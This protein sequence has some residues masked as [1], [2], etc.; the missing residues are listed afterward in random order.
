VNDSG[1]EHPVRGIQDWAE[2]RHQEDQPAPY[3]SRGEGLGIP[4]K[5]SHWA[6]GRQIEQT[7][8]DAPVD[9]RRL[10]AR[11]GVGGWL[12]QNSLS[13]QSLGSRGSSEFWRVS[14]LF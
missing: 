14:N 2:G 9:S 1:S 4:R 3:H 5:E 12:I 13:S 10:T 8:F 11:S 7:S 6:Y